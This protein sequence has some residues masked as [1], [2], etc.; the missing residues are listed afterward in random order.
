MDK[1]LV[2]MSTYNGEKYLREQID[3]ILQQSGCEVELFIRDDGSTDAT[4]NILNKY[5]NENKLYWYSDDQNLGAAFSFLSLVKSCSYCKY[6]AFADQDDIWDSD[7]LVTAISFL[8]NISTPAIYYSNALLVDSDANSFEIPVYKKKQKVSFKSVV[9]GGN[10][11]GCTMVFNDSLAN[12]IKTKLL[13]KNVIMHDYYLAAVCMSLGGKIIYDPKC[14]MK[15]RQHSN[16][17]IG[18]KTNK[19]S[20]LAERINFLKNGRKITMDLQCKSIVELYDDIEPDKKLFLTKVEHYKSNIF[21]RCSLACSLDAD[22]S[23][24]NR[25]IIIRLSTLLGKC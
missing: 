24:F 21:K 9:C 14:H 12:K 3:S 8:K 10:I 2:L 20:A 17:V 23:S 25:N 18:I 1:V 19:I 4:C 11:L 15:Y 22:F 13:P 7:K 16:N 5:K 6:Y